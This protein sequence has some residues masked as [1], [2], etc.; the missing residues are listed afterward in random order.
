MGRIGGTLGFVLCLGLSFSAWG[1]RGG[2]VNS[3]HFDAR[4]K[5][6]ECL[7]YRGLQRRVQ[8]TLEEQR[9]QI[10]SDRY[11]VNQR[12]EALLQCARERGV[13][14]VLDSGRYPLED[15]ESLL[16]EVCLEQYELW[17]S[18]GLRIQMARGDI[19]ESV[20]ELENVDE[21]L[22]ENCVA[23]PPNNS[24]REDSARLF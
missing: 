22:R 15:R 14:E 13:G 8:R 24:F 10:K 11:L 5:G 16:A 4:E 7:V 3:I 21:Y 19:R 6:K 23:W 20:T 18:P 2:A 17:L 1:G 9:R 12:R